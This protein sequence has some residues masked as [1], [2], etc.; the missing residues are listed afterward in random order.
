MVKRSGLPAKP[1][2]L[3]LAV[4][5]SGLWACDTAPSTAPAGDKAAAAK[6]ADPA[7]SKPS[8]A[9]VDRDALRR[10]AR[11]LTDAFQA[12]LKDQLMAGLQAGGPAAAIQMCRMQA[13][14]IGEAAGAAVGKPGWSVERT[15]SRVRNPENAPLDW[16]RAPL[17]QLSE[18]L[19]AGKAPPEAP[20]EWDAVIDVDGKPQYRYMRAI[21]TAPLC[22]QC[23]GPKESL[24]PS[25]VQRLSASYPN[26]QATGYAVGELRGAFVVT[27]PL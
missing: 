22:L 16:Q 9:P 27:A 23:H 21:P 25:V 14:L 26:D 1:L 15:S 17:A 5:L 13:P 8:H 10:G 7:P 3:A 11:E 6:S 18:K 19:R 24:S 20:I 2:R 12:K 4:M